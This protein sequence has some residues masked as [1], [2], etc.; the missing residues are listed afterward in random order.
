MDHYEG[1][2]TYSVKHLPIVKDY[3][4]RLGL[5]ELVNHLVPSEMN[6]E[7]GVY[8]L[9]MVLDTLSGRNPLYRLEEFFE[10]QDTELLLGKKVDA[11]LFNDVN[12]GRFIDQ[13]FGV[14]AVK[15]FK[16]ISVRAVSVFGL[17]CRHVH[18]DTTSRSVYGDYEAY[19]N[20][21]FEI[22]YGHSKD[23]RPDLKQFLISMLCVDRNVPVFGK[24][25][26]GNASDKSLNN[27]VLSEI[28]KYMA[29]HGLGAGAFIYVADSAAVT[30]ENL[31]TMGKDILFISRL[32]ANFKECGRV[33]KEAVKVDPMSR[34]IFTKF[35][36]PKY[37]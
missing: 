11:K 27:D 24:I 9:G 10:E 23:H 26:D 20:D 17:N 34:P 7:P 15:I 19:G 21:P 28:S 29:V 37:S 12:V 22:T 8:F 3:A 6:L 13:V 5:V 16:A 1:I 14:G 2:E 31:K 4:D 32:P 33:I 25:E 36:L 35:K 30:K 18:F